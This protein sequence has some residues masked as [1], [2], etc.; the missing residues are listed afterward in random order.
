MVTPYPY[1]I[2][3]FTAKVHIMRF[4]APGYVVVCPIF[5]IVKVFGLILRGSASPISVP[6]CDGTEVESLMSG[7]DATT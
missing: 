5:R 1:S 4:T 6:S 2:G 7:I 3:T